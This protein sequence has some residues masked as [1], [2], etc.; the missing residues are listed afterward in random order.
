MNPVGIKIKL[1][2]WKSLL[3]D[4]VLHNLNESHLERIFRNKELFFEMESFLERFELPVFEEEIKVDR[5]EVFEKF[6]FLKQENSTQDTLNKLHEISLADYLVVL[7]MRLTPASEQNENGIPPLNS[8][9][10]KASFEPFNSQ[11]SKAVRAFEKHSERFQKCFW[12]KS[13]GTPA[14]KQEYVKGV[15]ID[16][17]ENHTWWNIF[18]HYQHGFIYEVRLPSGHGARWRKD[19]LEFIGFVGPFDRVKKG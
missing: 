1:D 16:I 10:L 15:V 8:E 5:R 12:G 7:G 11:V 3:S 19:S 17:L 18:G 9:V 6:S 13:Q 2:K 4:G 14:E